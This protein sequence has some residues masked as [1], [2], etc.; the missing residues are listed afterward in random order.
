MDPRSLGSPKIDTLGL[1]AGNAIFPTKLR[2]GIWALTSISRPQLR[3]RRR[4]CQRRTN[5]WHAFTKYPLPRGYQPELDV[6]EIL[7]LDT[8]NW[9]QNLI[10]ILNW[11]VELG[12]VDINNSMVRLSNFLE[13]TK[14][15]HLQA[16]LHMCPYL[17]N[18]DISKL[19]FDPSIPRDSGKFSVGKNW[20]EHYP[21]ANGELPPNTTYTLVPPVRITCFLEADHTGDQ[22]TRRAYF[23]I[24]IYINCELISWYSN[25]Q[26][27]VEDSSF[28]S[29]IICDQIA[30]ENFEALTYK[31]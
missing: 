15:G 4:D 24:L 11:I 6:S 1:T 13:N 19:V 2:P 9:F 22:Q 18:Y 8:S 27:T 25:R 7:G 14:A 29:E 5:I 16:S 21:Y 17:K 23:G 26:N 10:G 3:L 30:C 28:S 20:K 31:L 12:H